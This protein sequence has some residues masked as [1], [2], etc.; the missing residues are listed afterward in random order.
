MNSVKESRASLYR[1]SRNDRIEKHNRQS[2]Q[3]AGRLTAVA[4]RHR[5]LQQKAIAFQR[6]ST[7]LAD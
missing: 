1:L 7:T 5:K 4:L 6:Y 3:I 2:D